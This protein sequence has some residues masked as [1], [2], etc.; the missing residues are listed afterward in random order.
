M[1]A[2]SNG[3]VDAGVLIH[4][5]QLTHMQSGLHKVLDLGAWWFRETGLPVPLGMNVVRKDLGPS[6]MRAIARTL[7]RS[8]DFGMA[9]RAEALAYAGGFARGLDHSLTDRFVQ[10]YVNDYSMELGEEGRR[11]VE[12]LLNRVSQTDKVARAISEWVPEG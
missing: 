6:T 11:S 3:E 2:V 9:N 4:E 5:G 10:L 8:I 7:K 1:D 12:E